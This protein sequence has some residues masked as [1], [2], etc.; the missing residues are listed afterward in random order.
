MKIGHNNVRTLFAGYSIVA[1]CLDDAEAKSMLI[2]SLADS[3]RFIVAVSVSAGLET[4]TISRS[5]GSATVWFSLAIFSPM[6]N[7]HPLYHR[8]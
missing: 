5:T 4:A 6:C 8:E 7:S 2:S 3:S 1:E